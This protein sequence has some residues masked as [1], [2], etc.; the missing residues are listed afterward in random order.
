MLVA[1]ARELLSKVEKGLFARPDFDPATYE[2][3]FTVATTEAAESW[4]WPEA[5]RRLRQISPHSTYRLLRIPT[6]NIP[7]ELENGSIDLALG[8]F[9]GLHGNNLVRQGILRIRPICMIRADH[10]IRGKRLTVKQF[11]TLEHIIVEAIGRNLTVDQTLAEHKIHRKVALYTSGYA[12]L[13]PIISNTDLVVTIPRALGMRLAATIPQ[14]RVIEPPVQIPPV[15]VTQ[16]W[17]R[18]LHNDARN[19]WL[20]NVLKETISEQH[21]VPERAE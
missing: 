9:A 17:H 10:P 6:N 8:F 3:R 20:R 15:L 14:L 11:Q 7:E 19:S 4:L 16:Y 13:A 12:C 5:F 1:S 18:K 21:E 2:G